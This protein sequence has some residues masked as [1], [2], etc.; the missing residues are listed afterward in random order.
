MCADFDVDAY[1]EESYDKKVNPAPDG[2]GADKGDGDQ[3]SEKPKEK[4]K[5][6]GGMYRLID[7]LS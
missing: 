7:D 4:D 5:E 6:T 3:S 1:L 2:S